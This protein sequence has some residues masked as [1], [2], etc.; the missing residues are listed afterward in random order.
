M[1]TPMT[2]MDIHARDQQ[3]V[4]DLQDKG[5]IIEIIWEKDWQALVNQRPEIKAYISQH[6]TY[7]HFKKYLNQDQI[8]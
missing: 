6:R 1:I 2:V 3:R 5:Y 7:T 8:I 4:L